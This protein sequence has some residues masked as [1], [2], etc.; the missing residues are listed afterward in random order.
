[1]KTSKF[2][3]FSSIPLLLTG[4]AQMPAMVT[5]LPSGTFS[6]LGN[7]N[8]NTPQRNNVS[9]QAVS[10]NSGQKGKNTGKGTRQ[11]VAP[12]MQPYTQD[13][14]MI[15][16]LATDGRACG[17]ASD[18][19]TA[20]NLA[21]FASVSLELSKMAALQAADS[22]R[23]VKASLDEVREKM[24][25][26]AWQTLWLPLAT[27]TV[28]G[29]A[30][31]TGEGLKA[32]AKQAKPSP[33]RAEVVT[34]LADYSKLAKEKYD[35]PYDFNV[36]FVDK[37]IEGSLRMLPGGTLVISPAFLARIEQEKDPARRGMILRYQIGHEVAH[38]L[39]RHQTK[40]EQFRLVDATFK[41]DNLSEILK[42]GKS[43]HSLP[44]QGGM[45]QLFNTSKYAMTVVSEARKKTCQFFDEIDALHK[46][47]ELE[48]DVCSVHM[49]SEL[50]RR[51]ASYRFNPVDAMDTYE[52]RKQKTPSTSPEKRQSCSSTQSH[53]DG[54]ERRENIKS[55]YKA[56]MGHRQ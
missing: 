27:E 14:A 56:V 19:G 29:Q 48:A 24:K 51:D 34:I 3:L 15:D 32:G 37:K 5:A 49:L 35:A 8:D 9:T 22:G 44:G 4:C 31:V 46:R 25:G 36:M 21:T 12:L 41:T 52:Q 47:Q 50:G 43:M 10:Q 16:L 40:W 1:M 39:R 23:D 13:K 33:V 7:N 6:L 55:F 42:Q 38:A 11:S 20:G 17:A 45:M 26:L 2:L 53:P 30:Y 18:T 54:P 28:I